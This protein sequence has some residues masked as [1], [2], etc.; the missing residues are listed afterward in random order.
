MNS[1]PLLA[2]ASFSRIPF[3]GSKANEGVPVGLIMATRNHRGGKEISLY[4][5][6][7]ETPFSLCS[8]EMDVYLGWKFSSVAAVIQNYLW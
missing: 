1:H 7:A 8:S 4:L 6:L 5:Q 2:S 3:I